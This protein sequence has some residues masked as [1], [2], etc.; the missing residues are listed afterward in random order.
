[1]AVALPDAAVPASADRE[2]P[3]LAIVDAVA[4]SV[5]AS[6]AAPERI[7][8]FHGTR[9]MDPGRL[10]VEGLRPLDAALPTIWKA[11]AALIPEV[12]ACELARLRDDMSAGHAGPHTYQLRAQSCRE[13]GPYAHLV[14]DV[15]V[16]PE[17]YSSVDYLAG[18]EIAVDVCCAV[19]ERFGV[20]APSRWATATVP[21]IVEFTGPAEHVQGALASALWYV[22][23]GLDGQ[24]TWYANWGFDGRGEAVPAARVVAV[25]VVDD[26]Q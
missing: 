9:V 6:A 24:R 22:R 7:H 23:A 5:G 25:T 10:P 26:A 15:L 2:N 17:A 16:H 11:I 8:Y 12:G 4:R 20:D 3:V 18:G 13:R 19:R 14:R 1:M 21:C